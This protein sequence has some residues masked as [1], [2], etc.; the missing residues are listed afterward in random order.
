MTSLEF[1]AQCRKMKKLGWR[2]WKTASDEIRMQKDGSQWITDPLC[3]VCSE[4]CGLDHS[5]RSDAAKELGLG[6]LIFGPIELAIEWP[7]DALPSD[8]TMYCRHE[9]LKAFGLERDKK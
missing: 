8:T 2:V 3:A 1:F 9:L 6:R 7:S 4:V 5:I